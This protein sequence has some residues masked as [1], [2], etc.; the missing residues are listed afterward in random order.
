MSAKAS[1][2]RSSHCSGAASSAPSAAKPLGELEQPAALAIEQARGRLQE[3]RVAAHRDREALLEVGDVEGALGSRELQPELAGFEHLAVLI[4]EHRQRDLAEEAAR[5]RLPVDVEEGRIGA[6]RAPFE[7]VQPPG[8]VG[9]DAHVVGH[10]VEQQAHAV[11]VQG[12]DQRLELGLRAELRVE[13]VEVDDVVAVG[14]ARPRRGQRRGVEMADAEPGEV[15][16]DLARRREAEARV[17]LQ[18]VGGA[19]HAGRRPVGHGG[20]QVPARQRPD[21]RPGGQRA[22][23]QLLVRA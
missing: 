12:L 23:R 20:P 22:L 3:L 9:T 6:D 1:W 2:R 13:V 19:G 15:G 4:A 16:H 14:R 11:L 17:E 18:A 7:H 10:E 21:D 8:I 5:A